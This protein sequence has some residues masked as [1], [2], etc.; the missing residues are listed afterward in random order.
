M[1][2]SQEIQGDETCEAN[3]LFG[4]SF[5]RKNVRFLPDLGDGVAAVVSHWKNWLKIT[6][7][8]S[9]VRDRCSKDSNSRWN[10]TWILS[11]L[12]LQWIV[13]CKME[14]DN[15]RVEGVGM[16]R[17]STRWE[18]TWRKRNTKWEYKVRLVGREPE[19]S[20]SLGLLWTSS[21]SNGAV[22]VNRLVCI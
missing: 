16:K 13:F 8:T 11:A 17:L 5:D 4:E 10:Q 9:M 12:K 2:G 19:A 22:V 1:S 6:V 15:P 18:E 21:H 20:Y 14:F 7:Q 3:A